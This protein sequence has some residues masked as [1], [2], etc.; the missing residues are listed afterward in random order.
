MLY[1]SHVSSTLKGGCI[2]DLS[3]RTVIYGPNSSGKTTLIQSILLAACG[4][5]TDMEGRDI[6]KSNTALAR[7]FTKGEEMRAMVQVSAT[8]EGEH[9]DTLHTWKMEPGKTRGYKKPVQ[10]VVDVNGAKVKDSPEFLFPVQSIAKMLGGSPDAV[11]SWLANQV[12]GEPTLENL[13]ASIPPALR[14]DTETIAK[15][16][17]CFDALELGGTCAKQASILRREATTAEKTAEK[18][19]EGVPTPLLQAQ[20]DEIKA[21]ISTLGQQLRP[22]SF[23]T[24]QEMPPGSLSPAEHEGL[25]QQRHALREEL[26]NISNAIE[27]I[28]FDPKAQSALNQVKK[29]KELVTQQVAGFGVETCMV[30]RQ[31]GEAEITAQVHAIVAAEGQLSPLIEKEKEIAALSARSNELA[32]ALGQVELGLQRPVYEPPPEEPEP[33]PVDESGLRGQISELQQKLAADG[34]AVQAWANAEAIEIQTAQTRA[35]ADRL[36]QIG[37]AL[38]KAGKKKVEQKVASF[39]DEV[40]SFLPGTEEF[41][42]DLQ[43][44]RVGIVRD[45]TLHSALGGAEESRVHMAIAAHQELDGSTVSVLIPPDRGW[46]ATT[47]QST[48]EALSACSS[49]VLIMSTVK[50]EPVEGW[51]ILDL[52]E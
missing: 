18:M 33:E 4:F 14:E 37:K 48:M 12:L 35:K 8:G 28:P 40:T 50:P 52:T 20:K 22:Q 46:D 51:Q 32:G 47:L 24:T 19:L 5:V 44:G 31:G 9:F 2:A 43:S 27:N 23:V 49:Q 16:E 26:D 11:A 10:S 34:A 6:V 29:L 41:G 25:V 3:P 30:C 45:D 15:R 17:K 13:L 7:L 36:A 38:K 21:A 1:I 42:V 39:S